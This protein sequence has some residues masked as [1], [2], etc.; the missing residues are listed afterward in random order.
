MTY[1]IDTHVLL[2]YVQGKEL[3][4][5]NILSVIENDNNT[6][7]YSNVSLWEIAIKL[8]IGKLK[9]S[10]S[11]RELESFLTYYGFLIFP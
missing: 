5:E 2:A 3:L 7:V 9:L 8:G 4:S 6:I 1:L 10:V 11:I